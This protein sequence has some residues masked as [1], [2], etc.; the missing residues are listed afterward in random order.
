MNER[1]RGIKLIGRRLFLQGAAGVVVGLP[2]LETFT[3]RS[4]GAAPAGVVV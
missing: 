4:A 2:L 3:P 1:K